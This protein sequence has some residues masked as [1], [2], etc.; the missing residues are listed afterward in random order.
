MPP[1][2]EDHQD[3]QSRDAA[4]AGWPRGGEAAGR[5]QEI[6]ARDAEAWR[7]EA[8]EEA[9]QLVAAG[10]EQ[11]A[12]LVS[13]AEAR[14]AELLAEAQAE[15]D[16]LRAEVEMARREHAAELDRS[17]AATGERRQRLRDEVTTLLGQV[18]ERS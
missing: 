5:L 3:G 16:R 13:E 8:R 1:P 18:D 2:V 7:V 12:Q 15:A 9:D 17:T 6:A 11:A 4:P 14:A 10:R